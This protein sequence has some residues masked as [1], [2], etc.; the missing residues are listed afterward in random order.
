MRRRAQLAGLL[1]DFFT[2]DFRESV[3]GLPGKL[4]IG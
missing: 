1:K 2:K 4:G 3:T